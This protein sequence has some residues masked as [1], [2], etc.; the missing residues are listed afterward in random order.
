ML[1]LSLC[2]LAACLLHVL[3]RLSWAEA[4]M[5]GW[6]MKQ[7]YRASNAQYDQAIKLLEH[8]ERNLKR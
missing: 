7:A 1:A 3:A 6:L 4:R 8:V 2:Y 5:W